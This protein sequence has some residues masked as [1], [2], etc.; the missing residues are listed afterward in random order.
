MTQHDLNRLRNKHPP[1]EM[2]QLSRRGFIHPDSG[3]DSILPCSQQDCVQ[4]T[5][6]QRVHWRKQYVSMPS[7]TLPTS[8]RW[9]RG[10][11]AR[12][13]SLLELCGHLQRVLVRDESPIDFEDERRIPV[14]LPLGND[15]RVDTIFEAMNDEGA[16]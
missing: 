15:T 14:R 11:S 4:F 16:P 1:T 13:G 5:R 6:N 8:A 10:Q 2:E 3:A 7:L 9:P 12:C